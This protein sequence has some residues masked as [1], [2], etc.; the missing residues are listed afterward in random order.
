MTDA[1]YELN[2]HLL[3]IT[4]VH[5]VIDVAI[6][7]HIAPANWNQTGINQ[8]TRVGQVF[9]GNSFK[10]SSILRQND[11]PYDTALNCTSQ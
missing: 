10:I 2:P 1:F 5:Y 3:H 9:H 11:R 7:I 4:K 8:T 6:G